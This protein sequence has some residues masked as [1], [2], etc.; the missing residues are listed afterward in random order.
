VLCVFVAA[1]RIEGHT[2]RYRSRFGLVP[3][4]RAALHIGTVAAGEIGQQR[5]EIAYVGDTLNTAARLLDAA[6]DGGRD[7][8]ASQALLQRLS[9][10]D[11]I[12]V[13]PL[14]PADAAG[15]REK[16]PLAALSLA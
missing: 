9:L 16:V 1:R 13:E 7:I 3:A 10:P 12:I 15:K 14:A 6:R 8:V 2:E 4:F 5:R 11:G